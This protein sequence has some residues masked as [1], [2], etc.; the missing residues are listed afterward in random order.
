MKA[1]KWDIEGCELV[2]VILREVRWMLYERRLGYC[3]I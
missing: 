3:D 2:G 1:C